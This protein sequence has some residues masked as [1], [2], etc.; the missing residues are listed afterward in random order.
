MLED[1][2]K[3]CQEPVAPV[4]MVSTVLGI[5][6]NTFLPAV[7]S[8]WMG[9]PDIYRNCEGGEPDFAQPCWGLGAYYTLP[10]W[11]GEPYLPL[12]CGGW[13]ADF[14]LPCSMGETQSCATLWSGGTWFIFVLWS[15]PGENC[16]VYVSHLFVVPVFLWINSGM[17]RQILKR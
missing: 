7:A 14:A 4:L 11:G 6:A 5:L 2:A 10:F 3:S 16:Q 17:M 15:K 12:P 8:W 13:G 9:G 1:C